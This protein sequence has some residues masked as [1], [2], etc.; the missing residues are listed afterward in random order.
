M[1]MWTCGGLVEVQF[2]GVA[3]VAE[4]CSIDREDESF[5]GRVVGGMLRVLNP[6]LVLK[7]QR[8]GN[9]P[10][11]PHKGKEFSAVWND[12]EPCW[13]ATLLEN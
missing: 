13:N 11:T 8:A 12:V 7:L 1:E 5:T 6:F 3:C 4:V 9:L 2:E 10:P